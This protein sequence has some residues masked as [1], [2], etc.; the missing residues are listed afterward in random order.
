[1]SAPTIRRNLEWD[2]SMTAKVCLDWSLLL[3]NNYTETKAWHLKFAQKASSEM[4][5]KK[6]SFEIARLSQTFDNKSWY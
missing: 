3:G 5:W 6:T 4:F 1:M 2:K